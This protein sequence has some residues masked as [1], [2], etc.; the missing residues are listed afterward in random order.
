MNKTHSVKFEIREYP[1]GTNDQ[2]FF[3][4][5]LFLFAFGFL[6]IFIEVDDKI[7]ARHTV[8]LSMILIIVWYLL[9]FFFQKPKIDGFIEIT[10][11][12]VNF[13][14]EEI[15]TEDIEFISINFKDYRGRIVPKRRE[16]PLPRFGINNEIY[17][18]SKSGVVYSSKFFVKRK[19]D[20]KKID[21]FVKIWIDKN[22]KTQYLVEDELIMSSN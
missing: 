18:Q 17:I 13:K 12:Y 4:L 1:S 7:I 5:I 9:K 3:V 14:G 19:K 11:D 20:R 21:R 16:Y 2:I 22:I 15:I 10:I 6:M 8:L